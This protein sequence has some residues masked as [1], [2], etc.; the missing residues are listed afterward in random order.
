MGRRYYVPFYGTLYQ[1]SGDT[2]LVEVRPANN[3][4]LRLRG[5]CVG[6][7]GEVGDAQEEILDLRVIR[8]TPSVTSGVT[9]TGGGLASPFSPGKEVSD[10]NFTAETF[11]AT[12]ATTSGSMH[13]LYFP[14]N[15]RNTPYVEWFPEEDDQL[16][17]LDGG[18]LIL[19]IGSAVN[20]DV[21]LKGWVCVEEE[22]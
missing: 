4:P 14:W 7:I 9:G 17:A 10:H 21:Q 12:P 18:A 20:G 2:D 11:N 16:R 22:G 15:L 19:R 6:Q 8:M 13:E 1:I 5:F 3:K